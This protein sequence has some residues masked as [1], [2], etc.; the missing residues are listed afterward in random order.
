[1]RQ[2]A[3]G[4]F[5]AVSLLM[6]YWVVEIHVCTWATGV[7]MDGSKVGRSWEG[8]EYGR[9]EEWEDRR[10]KGAEGQED[11]MMG[12]WTERRKDDRMDG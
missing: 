1:M 8:H 6:S 7:M 12:G 3:S 2:W 4:D 10:R 11:R 9:M 5:R